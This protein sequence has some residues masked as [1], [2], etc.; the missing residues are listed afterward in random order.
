MNYIPKHF[1]AKEIFPPSTI[2]DHMHNGGVK[3]SIWRLMDDR[4]L[5]TADKLQ[6]RYGTTICND[7]KWG[8]A[9]RYRG[10]RSI[11]E[12]IDW[13]QYK[14]NEMIK[15]VFSTFT[16]Q[17]CFGRALDLIFKDIKTSEVLEDIKNNFDKT[18]FQYIK[19]IEEGV[20]WFHF[21]CRNQGTDKILYFSS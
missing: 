6:E 7:Y 13:K 17:H 9:V 14:A 3:D 12:L 11:T 20:S 16:S 21:D 19:A 4:V 2:K 8:G 18:I 1:D 10:F 5:W 15:P